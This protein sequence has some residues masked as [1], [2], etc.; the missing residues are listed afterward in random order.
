ME[1]G[2]AQL[3]MK[4]TIMMKTNKKHKPQHSDQIAKIRAAKSKECYSVC[5]CIK[6]LQ[7]LVD[8]QN[9]TGASPDIIDYVYDV[10]KH[11]RSREEA[12]TV[13]LNETLVPLQ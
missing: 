2:C 13:L 4:I 11:L 5:T 6:E 9:E 7:N 8:I 12:L 10:I 3:Y 1:H